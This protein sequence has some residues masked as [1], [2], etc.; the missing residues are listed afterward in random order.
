MDNSSKIVWSKGP[1]KDEMEEFKRVVES[2]WE[3]H[4]TKDAK[5]FNIT[6]KDLEKVYSKSQPKLLNDATWRKL[7]NSDS[8]KSTTIEKILKT[9]KANNVKRDISRILN[10]FIHRKMDAPIVLQ[11]IPK[12]E[13][14]P[15]LI[16]G[17][18]RLMFCKFLGIRPKIITIEMD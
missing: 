3:L 10:Q 18:T 2:V 17:N 8:W 14:S 11:F 1:F 12:H 6:L 7:E 5:E 15:E 9:F 13:H 16:A 4:P